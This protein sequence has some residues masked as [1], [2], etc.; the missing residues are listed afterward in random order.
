VGGI[1]LLLAL[2]SLGVLSVNYTGLLFIVL[3]FVLFIVDIKAP[4]HGVLTVG[5]IVS[6][7][8]GSLVLFNSSYARVSI[9]LVVT[10][11]LAT[12][13]FFAFVVAKAVGAQRRRPTTGAEG[14]IGEIAIVRTALTPAGTVLIKGELWKAE[15]DG[16]TIERGRR[17]EVL[18]RDGFRLWVRPVDGEG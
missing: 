11:G 10:V 13:A 4:T 8:I 7:I 2:Y 1:C 3:A 14:L 16:V 5:G 18:R 15:T 9:S 6:F 17:V 12:G